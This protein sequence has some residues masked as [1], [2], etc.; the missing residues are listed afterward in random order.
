MHVIIG[1]PYK[2]GVLISVIAVVQSNVQGLVLGSIAFSCVVVQRVLGKVNVEIIKNGMGL[3]MQRAM[4]REVDC[5]MGKQHS[6]S[7]GYKQIIGPKNAKVRLE[8]FI[9]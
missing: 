2:T 9:Y 1:V 7:Q 6:I 4:M 5:D 8:R 3:D